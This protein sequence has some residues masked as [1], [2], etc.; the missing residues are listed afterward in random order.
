[1]CWSPYFTPG[2]PITKGLLLMLSTRLATAMSRDV[3][4][5]VRC[6]TR[7]VVQSAPPPFS[8]CLLH[9]TLVC[10]IAVRGITYEYLHSFPF[11]V[12]VCL[13][14]P[15]SLVVCLS[16]PLHHAS[17]RAAISVSNGDS[18]WFMFMFMVLMVRHECWQASQPELLLIPVR[19][20][21]CM[22]R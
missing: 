10:V 20:G 18:P 1:M 4:W 17:E 14:Y 22:M 2:L 15:L 8:M 16:S 21:T 3:L 12:R 9:T 5:S 13:S 19:C 7:Y 6:V 11:Y